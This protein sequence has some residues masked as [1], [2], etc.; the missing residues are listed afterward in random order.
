MTSYLRDVNSLWYILSNNVVKAP[1]PKTACLNKNKGPFL[2]GCLCSE[3]EY[4]ASYVKLERISDYFYVLSGAHPAKSYISV[5]CLNSPRNHG[6]LNHL[7]KCK[8]H[9]RGVN[10]KITF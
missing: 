5:P 8:Y 7:L 9:L 1:F 4:S 10:M 2:F 3:S 6:S